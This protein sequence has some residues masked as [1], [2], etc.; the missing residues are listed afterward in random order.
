VRKTARSASI[1]NEPVTACLP[2]SGLPVGLDQ[3]EIHFADMNGDGIQDIVRLRRGDVQYWPGRGNGM[4]GTGRRDDC[5]EKT[6]ADNRYIQM[7]SS[8]QF[9]DIQATTLR[10]D[11]VNGDGLD[12]LV[13]VRF[14]AIDIW[15]N[16]DGTGWTE[17]HIIRGTPES[18]S[19]ANRVRLADV[20]GSGTRDI[21]WGDGGRYRYID[22]QGGK[23]PGML[24]RIENGLGKSTDIE[25]STS[26][27]EM[28][29]ADRRGVTCDPVTK[30]WT[31]PWCT[32]MPIVAL[33]V[34]RVTDSDNLQIAGKPPCTYV[35]EYDYRDPVFEGRQR[36]FRGFRKTRTRRIGDENSPTDF[37]DSTF[38]LGECTD[39]TVEGFGDNGVDDCSAA[40]RWRDNPREAL[41]GLA[42]LTER[43]DENNVYLST[44]ASTYRLR[45]LYTGLDGR[46][47]RHAFE[48][49]KKTLLYDTALGPAPSLGAV[50]PCQDADP[51]CI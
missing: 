20:N 8:P 36:E 9:S 48:S 35:I 4:W 26:T 28:L 21:V 14:D 31:S 49:K 19:F 46:A 34:K 25:Y 42:V 18:P 29:A 27:E 40:E 38:L 6:F 24:A 3:A 23:R 1:S 50:A 13:E 30:P 44:E 33:L 17:R 10:I 7:A 37:T 15:L 11:D 12:D 2:A 45:H 16:V 43:Y 39:E 5:P 47:V 41:K 51:R 22:L 32:K